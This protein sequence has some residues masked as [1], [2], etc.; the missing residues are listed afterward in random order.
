MK[1][2]SEMQNIKTLSANVYKVLKATEGAKVEHLCRK[3]GISMR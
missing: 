2:D 1:W 3:I